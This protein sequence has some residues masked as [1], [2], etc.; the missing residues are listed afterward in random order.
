MPSITPFIL[1]ANLSDA[2]TTN[3]NITENFIADDDID[4]YDYN[5]TNATNLT[6]DNSDNQDEIDQHGLIVLIM[7]IVLCCPILCFIACGYCASCNNCCINRSSSSR[8]WEKDRKRA[9]KLAKKNAKKEREVVKCKLSASF[10]KNA[11]KENR[12]CHREHAEKCGENDCAICM[13]PIV[14]DKRRMLFHCN[15][16]KKKNIYLNCGHNFHISCLQAW[17]KSKALNNESIICP[18]C[19]KVIAYN[20]P[21]ETITNLRFYPVYDSDSDSIDSRDYY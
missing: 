6:N 2:N 19:R 5:F 7:F 18:L 3:T 16:D 14:F 4:F 9:I 11:N 13:T 20:P 12:E 15:S 10:I 17:V 8:Q 21:K 1:L